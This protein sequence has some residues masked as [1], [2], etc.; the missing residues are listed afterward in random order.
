MEVFGGN[1]YVEDGPMARLFREAPVNSIWEGSGNVMCLDVLRAIARHPDSMQLLLDDL[2]RRAGDDV[3]LRSEIAALRDALRQPPEQL[4]AAARR[5]TQKLM[6]AV[7]AVLMRGQAAAA[8]A[9]AFLA[10]RYDS[11]WG[12]V[13]GALDGRADCGAVLAQAWRE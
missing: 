12:R 8:S 2:Q 5:Y 1:G 7:Q 4:E 3:R 10:S 13:F 9:D 6:L 11:D